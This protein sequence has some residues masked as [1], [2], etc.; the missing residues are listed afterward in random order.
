MG[1]QLLKLN[2]QEPPRKE[3]RHPH[4]LSFAA[5]GT[6]GSRALFLF[7]L[8]P[9]P[10]PIESKISPARIGLEFFDFSPSAVVSELGIPPR[11]QQHPPCPHLDYPL[12]APRDTESFL[13]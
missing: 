10:L 13:L 1:I 9:R 12:L 11:P 6:A 8:L 2:P 3:T 4:P 5:G 7:L